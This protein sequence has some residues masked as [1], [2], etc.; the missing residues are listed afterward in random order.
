MQTRITSSAFI[1][2]DEKVLLMKR[3]LHKKL[4]AGK[5]A[6]VGGHIDLQDIKNPRALKLK[7][8]CYREIEE[9][10][11]ITKSQIKTLTLRYIAVIQVENEIRIH[12][13]HIAQLK[14]EVPP[15]NKC[16]EGELHWLNKSE[17]ENLPMSTTVKTAI[18]HWLNHNKS[19]TIHL[20]AVK[21]DIA[22]I[23]EL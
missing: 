8:T 21:N 11:G 22:T 6:G 23:T 2:Y 1:T 14:K 12:Y 19:E 15:H 13:H 10:T 18:T 7:K 3:G 20:I 4:G 5:W 9:E 17:I 16:N